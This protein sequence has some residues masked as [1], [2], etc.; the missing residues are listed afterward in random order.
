MHY[1]GML[2]SS[3]N[4]GEPAI[5]FVLGRFHTEALKTVSAIDQRVAACKSVLCYSCGNVSSTGFK[6]TALPELERHCS[7]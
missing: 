5:G 2:F 1:W 6:S 7:D 4:L 3:W